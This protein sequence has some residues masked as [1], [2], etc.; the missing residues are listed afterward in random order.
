MATQGADAAATAL[1]E[2]YSLD[3]ANILLDLGGVGDGLTKIAPPATNTAARAPTLLSI[4][5]FCSK[6]FIAKSDLAAWTAVS[7]GT[8]VMTSVPLIV[9]RSYRACRAGFCGGEDVG[10]EPLRVPLSQIFDVLLQLCDK[11]FAQRRRGTPSS[12]KCHKVWLMMFFGNLHAARHFR[13]RQG[14]VFKPLRDRVMEVPL[15]EPAAK[16]V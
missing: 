12:D 10:I 4:L 2:G 14:L 9:A 11:L 6:A 3:K 7:H 1:V 8:D 5:H 16:V 13:V 15:I